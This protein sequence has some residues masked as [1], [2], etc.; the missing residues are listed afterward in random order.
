MSRHPDW[1]E[2]S[3]PPVP[4]GFL[5]WLAVP[6][7]GDEGSGAPSAE[8]LLEAALGSLRLA[9][10]PEG[11]ERRGAFHLLAADAFATWA[12]KAGLDRDRPED[13]L[14]E[15]AAVLARGPE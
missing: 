2:G 1:L 9:L 4:A 12:A 10:T 15:M 3:D 5:P 11:R 14:A 13:W 6:G 7:V 8:A